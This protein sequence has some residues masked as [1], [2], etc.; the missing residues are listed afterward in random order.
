MS[1]IENNKLLKTLKRGP[2]EKN[3]INNTQTKSIYFEI[4]KATDSD[5]SICHRVIR[6][7]YNREDKRPFTCFWWIKFKNTLHVYGELRFRNRLNRIVGVWKKRYI[8]LTLA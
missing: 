4:K 6:R 3:K 7:F 5:L 8:L 2:V 1:K